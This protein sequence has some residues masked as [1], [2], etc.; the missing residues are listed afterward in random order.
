MTDFQY[1]MQRYGERAS[2]YIKILLYTFRKYKKSKQ[3]RLF[4]LLFF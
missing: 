3:T 2:I 4:W 1:D